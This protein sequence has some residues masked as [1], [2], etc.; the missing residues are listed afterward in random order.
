MLGDVLFRKEK[1]KK[2][3]HFPTPGNRVM[4]KRDT[5][6]QE[7]QRLG[8]SPLPFLHLLSLMSSGRIPS[9]TWASC[10]VGCGNNGMKGKTAGIQ[11]TP[12]AGY[13]A[14]LQNVHINQG[15]AHC[16]EEWGGARRLIASRGPR[17]K[18]RGCSVKR[19]Q[20]QQ[21][22]GVTDSSPRC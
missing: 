21:K 2:N 8:S 16:W 17:L 7:I 22:G 11:L 15:P 14:W 3:W 1:K 4:G 9:F 10:P 6:E 12:L 5:G 13:L 18:W 19:L 20:D